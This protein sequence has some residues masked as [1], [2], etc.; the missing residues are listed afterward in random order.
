MK[1]EQNRELLTLFADIIRHTHSLEELLQT[2]VQL[3]TRIMRSDRCSIMLQEEGGGE[4]SI[5]ASTGMPEELTGKVRVLPGEGIAGSVFSSG[6]FRFGTVEGDRSGRY[7]TQQF[8]V[9]PIIY[10]ERTLG[11][12]NVANR[13]DDSPFEEEDADLLQSLA[14]IVGVAVDRS[15]LAQSMLTTKVQLERTL[16]GL[17]VGIILVNPEGTVLHSN[18]RSGELLGRGEMA[19]GS[20]LKNAESCPELDELLS[21]SETCRLLHQRVVRELKAHTGLEEVERPLRITATYLEE[22]GDVVLL[23]EDLT[24]NHEVEQLRRLDVMKTNFMALVSHELRTPI[25]TLRG[26]ATLLTSFYSTGFDETQRNLLNMVA[27]STERLTNV[28]NMIID[29][30]LIEQQQLSIAPQ[31]G[32]LDELVEELVTAREKELRVKH[33]RI[34]RDFAAPPVRALFDA[35]RFGQAV[36]AVLDNAIKF[37]KPKSEVRIALGRDD[38]KNILLRIHNEGDPI[39]ADQRERVFDLFY[40]AED[41]M[42]RRQGGT[43]LGLYLARQI[44]QLHGGHLRILDAENGAS[45]EFML[46]HSG[47]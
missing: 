23:L 5:V 22:T 43:G 11:T 20:S 13:E 16:H 4:L 32:L 3:V 7:A 21:L 38:D 25:T 12:I 15:R 30:S 17:P 42:T 27:G 14:N 31:V 1:P 36:S 10:D 8:L 29:A 37:A 26:A 41:A 6:E 2:T 44:A 35:E 24:L 40:Q 34:S 46:P 19:S 45:L 9:C 18:R 47:V 39:A 28:V 33:L